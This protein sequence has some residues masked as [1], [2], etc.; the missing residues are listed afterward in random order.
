[1]PFK[2][3]YCARLFKH[4]RSRDRH[5]KLHTGDRRYRCPHCEAAFS[6]RYANLTLSL[7]YSFC[8]GLNFKQLAIKILFYVVNTYY[9]IFVY[10]NEKIVS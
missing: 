9:I 10:D 4:K 6:R 5:T 2:C 1:M 3:D 8:M 7:L